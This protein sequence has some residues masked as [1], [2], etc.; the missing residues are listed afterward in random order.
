MGLVSVHTVQKRYSMTHEEFNDRLFN[1]LNETE[2]L[3]IVDIDTNDKNKTF[4]V[5]VQDGSQFII[6]TS[7]YGKLF[8]IR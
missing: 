6:S 3:P 4:K 5:V 2:E 1:A 8:I 7:P